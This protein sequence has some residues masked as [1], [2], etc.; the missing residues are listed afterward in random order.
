MIRQTRQKVNDFE[1]ENRMKEVGKILIVAGA[2][3]V[4]AG[5]LLLSGI[6]IPL[7]RL[8]GDIRIERENFR[9]YF[10]V[11]TS[12]L[13]SVVLSLLFVLFGRLLKK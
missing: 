10:P 3:A 4:A 6:R 13:V 11:T 1:V 12:V 2:V 5:L 9:F 7:G 8:P